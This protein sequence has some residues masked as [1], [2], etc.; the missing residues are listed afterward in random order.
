L[1]LTVP[2]TPVRIAP[3]QYLEPSDDRREEH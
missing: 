1:T 3:L 2:E